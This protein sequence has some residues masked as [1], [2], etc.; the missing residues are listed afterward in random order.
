MQETL[1]VSAMWGRSKAVRE[2]LL[3]FRNAV[4]RGLE[5]V[6]SLLALLLLAPIML[7]IAIAVKLSS[8]G[9]IFF[10]D[11][12][13]GREGRYFY[14]LKFRTMF[15]NSDE[16]LEKHLA[17][18]SSAHEEW[19]EYA[20]LKSFDP[21]VTKMGRFL[22]RHSLDEFPQLINLLRGEMVLIGPRPYLPEELNKMDEH[23]DI[24]LKA[25][26]GITGL[27]QVSG[28]NELTFE[29]RLE[30]DAWYVR[31]RSLW[32]D[33]LLLFKTFKVVLEGKGV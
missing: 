26:P 25:T 14:C 4:K 22:R 1:I 27:W 24:I 19:E 6:F 29:D 30:I 17:N 20:K 9:P 32:L 5:I 3:E 33:L 2:P 18:N 10:A 15:V 23:A 7:A 8:P 31:N 21:R 13:L 16:I 12:R 11:R 28:R